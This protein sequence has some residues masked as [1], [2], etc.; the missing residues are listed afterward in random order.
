M[1][2]GIPIF[3]CCLSILQCYSS[4][5]IEEDNSRRALFWFW[6]S[7]VE[8]KQP[9]L[10]TPPS[11]VETPKAATSSDV[12]TVQSTKRIVSEVPV[13]KKPSPIVPNATQPAKKSI[14]TTSAPK[15]VSHRDGVK[16]SGG[17]YATVI[18]KVS[19]KVFMSYNSIQNLK[20]IL[21]TII[22]FHFCDKPILQLHFC[23]SYS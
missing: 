6:N 14:F 5:Q 19:N 20:Y 23:K 16:L 9:S 2:L 18:H 8:K 13:L 11:V 3:F 1:K 10:I 17:T 7:K 21:H 12:S 15:D 4:N 22:D